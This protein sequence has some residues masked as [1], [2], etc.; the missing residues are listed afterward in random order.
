MLARTT[1]RTGASIITATL[2]S[3]VLASQ[4]VAATWYQPVPLTSSGRAV[5]GG[6]VTLGSSKAVAVYENNGRIV[7]RRS[8]NSGAT[9]LSPLRLADNADAPAIA[10]KGTSVDVVWAKSERVR[11]ARSTNSGTSFR[12][13]M[14]LSPKNKL[15]MAPTV[16][17]G[18]NGLVIVAWLQVNSLNDLGGDAPWNVRVRV[19]TNGGAS[20]GTARTLGQGWQVVAA[21]GNGVAYVAFDGFRSPMSSDPVIQVHRTVDGGASWKAPAHLSVKTLLR[22]M[23]GMSLTAAG[24][25]AYLAYTDTIDDDGE[26]PLWI[27]YRRTTDK[28][29]TWSAA[30]DLTSRTG[31]DTFDPQISLKGGVVRVAFARGP[32]FAQTVYYTQSGNGLTWTPMEKVTVGVDEHAAGV[33]HATRIIVL[34]TGFDAASDGG[35]RKSDVFVRT[36]SP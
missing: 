11:Y 24:K 23:W 30:R 19:S 17:R 7:V 34:Y 2:L 32:G 8:T 29:K 9:W 15:V 35:L 18:P 28:G 4:A 6:L 12:A 1:R 14:A 33:G 26:T 22:G 25:Q 27:R 5:A 36:G 13:P 10:G 20:F 31:Q 16:A 21:A 3:L